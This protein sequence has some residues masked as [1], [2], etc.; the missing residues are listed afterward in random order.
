[1]STVYRIEDDEGIGPFGRC[2]IQSMHAMPLPEDEGISHTLITRERRFAFMRLDLVFKW[3]NTESLEELV[4]SGFTLF[5]LQLSPGAIVAQSTTQ[6]IFNC[7]GIERRNV[8]DIAKLFK[9]HN[10]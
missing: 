10:S 8:L 1:M 7:D 9:E 6:C 2:F 4:D 5:E 3:M